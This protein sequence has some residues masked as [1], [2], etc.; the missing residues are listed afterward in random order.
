[1]KRDEKGELGTIR[2]TNKQQTQN[3]KVK[4]KMNNDEEDE[5]R[6]GLGRVW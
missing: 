6:G 4:M 5:E 1:M 2:Q 3:A